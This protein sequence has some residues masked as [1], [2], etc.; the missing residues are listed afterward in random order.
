MASRAVAD[1]A[2]TAT[3][4]AAYGKAIEG[5]RGPLDGIHDFSR[6][7][8]AIEVKTVVGIGHLL[9]ISHLEQLETVGLTSL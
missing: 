5:W 1:G 9:K 3:I 7:G 6:S 4:S 8:V 2:V